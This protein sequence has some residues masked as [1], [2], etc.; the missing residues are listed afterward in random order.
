MDAEV[1]AVQPPLVDALAAGTAQ[2]QAIAD[3]IVQEQK[4]QHVAGGAEAGEEAEGE[5]DATNKR[6]FEPGLEGEVNGDGPVRKKV[7]SGPEE[8]PAAVSSST[9]GSL[10]H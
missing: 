2:A 3:R 5:E 6:K 7:Y 10:S 4:S 1:E 8:N 9:V